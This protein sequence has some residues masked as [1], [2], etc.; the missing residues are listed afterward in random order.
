MDLFGKK[1]IAELEQKVERLK[2]EKEGILMLY[3]TTIKNHEQLEHE[4]RSL[5]AGSEGLKAVMEGKNKKVRELEE[6]VRLLELDIKDS[7]MMIKDR[8]EKINAA[9]DRLNKMVG[10][11]R[12]F[13][14]EVKEYRRLFEI[15]EN[16]DIVK[17]RK[18]RGEA[19]NTKSK[20]IR[21]KKLKQ[22]EAHTEKIFK[23]IEEYKKLSLKKYSKGIKFTE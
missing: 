9:K 4:Y 21:D 7:E 16:K 22:L 12:F 14:T 6:K 3:S 20:R 5:K 2:E 10:E 23:M 11:I 18:L 17:F 13:N 19:L 8:E 15:I 1:R